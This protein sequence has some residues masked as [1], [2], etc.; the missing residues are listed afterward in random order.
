MR[1][2]LFST[3]ALIVVALSLGFAAA[4]AQSADPSQPGKTPP[5][6]T[7][8][9]AVFV[10]GKLNVP[11]APADSQTVPAKF[12]ERNARVDKLPIMA[13][14]LGLSDQQ[15]RRI[16]AGTAIE[17]LGI[18]APSPPPAPPPGPAPAAEAQA[19]A[20]APAGTAS[21]TTRRRS[22]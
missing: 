21:A 1:S 7:E 17:F 10:N 18:A 8:S 6:P 19:P 14:P 13:R 15:R 16:L 3:T 4:S 11:G 5:A 2:Q 22:R 12:S 20:P 9:T